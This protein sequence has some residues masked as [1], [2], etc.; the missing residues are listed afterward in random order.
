MENT[1]GVGNTGSRSAFAVLVVQAVEWPAH[2]PVRIDTKNPRSRA[3]LR[4]TNKLD[5][6]KSEYIQN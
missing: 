6:R 3:V 1:R 4:E 5:C 2:S